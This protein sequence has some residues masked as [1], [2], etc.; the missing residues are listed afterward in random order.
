MYIELNTTD[1]S[2]ALNGFVA[3]FCRE[4]KS[5]V[6]SFISIQK[7]CLFAKFSREKEKAI[8]RSDISIWTFSRKA[9]NWRNE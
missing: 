8:E 6:H 3:V 4:W 1:S 7:F 5:I 9:S 2:D